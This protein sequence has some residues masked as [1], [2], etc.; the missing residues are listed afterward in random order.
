[1]LATPEAGSSSCRIPARVAIVCALLR[2]TFPFVWALAYHV[3]CEATPEACDAT[4]WLLY[5]R[6]GRRHGLHHLLLH[7]GHRLCAARACC[8]LYPRTGHARRDL[9]LLWP[10]FLRRDLC[11]DDGGD[12]YSS[13]VV[14]GL[15]R[16]LHH[17][18]LLP[19]AWE[20]I[21]EVRCELLLDVARECLPVYLVQERDG[22][23]VFLPSFVQVVHTLPLTHVWHA[24][25][26]SPEPNECAAS[27]DAVF[28]EALLDHPAPRAL[29]NCTPRPLFACDDLR[30]QIGEFSDHH[31]HLHN[32]HRARV[33]ARFFRS[34]DSARLSEPP[35]QHQHIVAVF[36]SVCR[37]IRCHTLIHS[38]QGNLWAARERVFVPSRHAPWPL[39]PFRRSS[40]EALLMP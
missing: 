18:A 5:A 35:G 40:C 25:K 3:S 4:S 8:F 31:L 33:V 20:R 34:S 17:H 39:W 13:F 38:K 1:M 14:L 29:P 10:W 2:R 12:L 22:V 19:L 24:R 6:H 9:T 7:I 36:C 26:L 11:L 30:G 16:Q 27:S 21:D 28:L 32:D 37:D 15:K 23:E